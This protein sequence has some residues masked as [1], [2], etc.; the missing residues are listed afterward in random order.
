MG[1][2]PGA[3]DGGSRNRGGGMMPVIDCAVVNER[4]LLPILAVTLTAALA[5][6]AFLTAN[7]LEKKDL[8]CTTR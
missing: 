4:L 2:V 1:V 7:C 5:G 3:N 6:S 8:R